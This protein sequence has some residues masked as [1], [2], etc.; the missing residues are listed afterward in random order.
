ME[1]LN[2]LF[3]GAASGTDN[4]VMTNWRTG[5]QA[6]GLRLRCKFPI[7]IATGGTPTLQ[8]LYDLVNAFIGS[9]TLRY[10]PSQEFLA[11]DGVPG[12]ELMDVY[13]AVFQDVP[14][15]DLGTV[16]TSFIGNASGTGAKTLTVDIEIPF[17]MP[18]HYG[19][20]RRPGWSQ[21]RTC[22]IEVAEG[23]TGGTMT[24]VGGAVT[25][26]A[27]NAQI[28]V[29]PLYRPG[30]DQFVPLLTYRRINSQRLDAV[31]PPGTTVLAWDANAATPSTAITKFRAF[32]GG[33]EVSSNI[34]PA[35]IWAEWQSYL[36]QGASDVFGAAPGQT[37]I[38][39]TDPTD[40]VDELPAGPLTL[41]LNNQ[42][43]TQIK[44]RILLYPDLGESAHD[45]ILEHAARTKGRSINASVKDASNADADFG[46]SA[47]RPVELLD[48]TDARFFTRSG[49]HVHPNGQRN[50]HIA[51]QEAAAAAAVHGA[52]SAAGGG[53][54]GG[55]HARKRIMLRIPGAVGWDGHSR[56]GDT[57][58]AGVKA[59]FTGLGVKG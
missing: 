39:I 4:L 29:L 15:N 56:G 17:T 16:G 43:V 22:R 18:N 25:R 47:T 24:T 28:D 50:A 10:G 13:R 35:N 3:T 41:T 48:S 2:S 42:D 14:Y 58:A 30:A 7:S 38:Y 51:P 32:I 52:T 12:G 9:L 57:R 55:V 46:S 40:D 34:I 1:L 23:A 27:G 49:M 8:N 20:Q 45:A 26:G 6:T 36:D 53:E 44:L 21:M 37:P 5:M 19:T 54:A 11:Y 31:G 59:A 33:A